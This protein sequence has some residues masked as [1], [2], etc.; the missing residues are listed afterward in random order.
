MKSFAARSV[1]LV[2]VHFLLLIVHGIAHRKLDIG[3]NRLQEAFIF[4]VIYATPLLAAVCIGIGRQSA[5]AA[6]LGISMA[7]SLIFGMINHFLLH[8]ADNALSVQAGAQGVLFQASAV[9]LVGI[10]LLTVGLCLQRLFASCDGK[11]EVHVG[12]ASVRER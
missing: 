2:V 11:T 8:G 12:A 9:A 5:G 3:M 7:A 6:S 10:E 1:L 4:V